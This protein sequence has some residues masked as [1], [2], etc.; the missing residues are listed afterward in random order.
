MAAWL[1]RV[2]VGFA[3]AA[4][5]HMFGCGAGRRSLHEAGQPL[6]IYFTMF[7]RPTLL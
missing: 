2:H 5:M 7:D 6:E 1:K 3:I 4:S